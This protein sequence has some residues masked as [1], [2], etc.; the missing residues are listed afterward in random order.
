VKTA[1]PSGKASFMIVFLSL[2]NFKAMIVAVK[3]LNLQVKR[4]LKAQ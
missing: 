2:L 3:P 1:F 4:F